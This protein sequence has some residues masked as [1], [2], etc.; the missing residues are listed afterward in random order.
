MFTA[1]VQQ[2]LLDVADM[3]VKSNYLYINT[4]P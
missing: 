2:S 4:I 1:T 3:A